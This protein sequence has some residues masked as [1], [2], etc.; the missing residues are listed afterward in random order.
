MR[1]YNTDLII[2]VLHAFL[3][4]C[5]LTGSRD[6]GAGV[7]ILRAGRGALSVAVVLIGRHACVTFEGAALT[8]RTKECI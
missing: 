4:V 5:L 1:H 2:L 6:G 3:G 7:S 8:D